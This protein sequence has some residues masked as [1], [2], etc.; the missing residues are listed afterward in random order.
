MKLKEVLIGLL[1]IVVI[2]GGA[3]GI[4]YARKR[5]KA[6]ELFPMLDEML[7]QKIGVDGDDISSQLFSAKPDP[8]YNGDADAKKLKAAE[9]G[10]WL[11]DDDEA[12]YAVLRGKTKGQLAS[13]NAS[14]LKLY[15]TSLD[16]F[17]KGVFGLCYG[18]AIFGNI[19]PDCGKYNKAMNIIK[20]S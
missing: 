10:I 14:M 15:G 19:G 1:A 3:L 5:K 12:V 6:R 18:D 11:P 9:G 13:I 2:I 4:N 16:D 17:I 8:T 20:N 7:N